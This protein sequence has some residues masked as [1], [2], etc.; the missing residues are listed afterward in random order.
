MK[1][2]RV[3]VSKDKLAEFCRRH[4]ILRLAFFGSVLRDDFRP[5]SDIDVLVEFEPG[6]VPGL[7]LIRIQDELSALLCGYKVDLVT[8]KFLNHRIRERVLSQMEV[9]YARG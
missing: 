4:H 7:A 6:H 1:P 5:D 3:E 2:N 9:Q 8:P